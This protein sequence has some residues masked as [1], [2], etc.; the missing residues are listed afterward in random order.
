MGGGDRDRV[1]DVGAADGAVARRVHDLRPAE[2]ARER[3]A[4]GDRL[5]DRDQ[6]GLDPELLD[7]EGRAGAA[8]AGLHLVGDEDDAVLVAEPSQALHELAGRDDEAA[9]ALDG[10]EDDRRHVLGRDARLEGVLERVEVGEGHPVGLRRER[11]EPRLVRMGLGGE[12]EREQRAAVEG[13]LEGDHGGA[14]RVGARELDRV[15]DRLGA[16]VEERGARLARDRRQ[17]EQPLGQADVV[18]VREDGEVGVREALDLIAHGLDHARVRMAD[19]HAA[20][21]AR[22][23]DERVPVDVRQGGAA[24]RGDDERQVDRERLGDDPLLP[25]Q[26]L[27]AARAR[28][29]GLELDCPC[30]SHGRSL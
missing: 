3:Q 27:G 1:A 14:P 15:L 11:P 12:A 21:A 28:D 26:N 8:E 6:V 18:L 5:G 13:A 19:V 17:R 30:R 23:V 29:V 2:H 16:R 22:E 10:L 20:D 25:G 9:L 24:P 4:G 7:G